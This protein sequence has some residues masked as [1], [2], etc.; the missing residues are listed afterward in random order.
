MFRIMRVRVHACVRLC[1]YGY[2]TRLMYR[3][4]LHTFGCVS[5][6]HLAPV[7]GFCAAIVLPTAVYALYIPS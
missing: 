5:Y 2:N 3:R 4:T 7:R 1:V 6:V